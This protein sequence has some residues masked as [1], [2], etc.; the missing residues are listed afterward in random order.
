[1]TAKLGVALFFAGGIAV[2][3][4]AAWLRR[5]TQRFL[6]RAVRAT[7][8]VEGV[9][10]EA[11]VLSGAGSDYSGLR[12]TA[13]D[14]SRHAVES[15]LGI[16][17]GAYRQGAA[18]TVLYDPDHPQQAVVDSWMELHAAWA[19]FALLGLGWCIAAGIAWFFVD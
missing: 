18:I 4:L 5:R 8:Q 3:L 13:A 17:G 9:H 14:G 10:S 7:A 2:L 16:P 12:F 11:S 6:A 15:R 19:I 1:M